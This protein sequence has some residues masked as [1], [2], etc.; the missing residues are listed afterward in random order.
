M[1][2]SFTEAKSV[3]NIVVLSIVAISVYIGFEPLIN[4]VPKGIAQSVISSSFGAIFV[5]ILTMY[6]LNKQTE[7]E[8]Q[9]KRNERL[10]EE[11]IKLFQL[12]LDIVEEML[13]DEKITAKEISRLPF[14]YVRLCML[15]E[16]APIKAFQKLQNKL[17]EIYNETEQEEAPIQDEEMSALIDLLLN[18]SNECRLD[19]QV[20]SEHLTDE[21]L[22]SSRDTI[23]ASNNKKDYTKFKFDGVELSKAR[24]IHA[25][26][27]SFAEQNPD[28]SLDEFKKKVPQS[29]EFRKNI[30]VLR[31]D[32]ENILK[33]TGT[34]R[35]YL[36]NDEC[37]VLSDATLCISNGQSLT[38]VQNW[39]QH[40]KLNGI[41]TT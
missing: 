20:S 29:T 24:Y 34:K 41:R 7:V 33:S 32:A 9:S 38:Q 35:H 15:C 11:R 6:L 16:E 8:Q 13:K 28:M 27:K 37:V 25:I 40:F 39:I 14:P 31:K 5:I 22:Q 23:E 19:L 10:F 21:L 30:W 17:N 18:F 36:K 26:I 12:I 3:K 4:S 1:S 2:K